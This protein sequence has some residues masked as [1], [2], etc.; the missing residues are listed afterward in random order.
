MTDLV[1]ARSTGMTR[2]SMECRR[3]FLGTSIAMLLIVLVGFAPTFYLRSYFPTARPPAPPY[4]Y[5]HGV[6]MTAWYLLLVAQTALVSARRSD[7]HR[8]LGIAG[9]VVAMGVLGTGLYVNTNLV[10]RLAALGVQL[11]PAT[12]QFIAFVVISGR[13]FLA[14]FAMLVAAAVLLRRHKAVH[15]RLM[16]LASLTTIGAALGP[17][18]WLGAAAVPL[19]PA[20]VG[21]GSVVVAAFIAAL[22]IRDW[23]VERRLHPVTLWGGLALI[24]ALPFMVRLVARAA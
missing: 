2:E 22:C 18:R 17:D 14:A 19:L 4:A 6:V 20:G 8:R 13:F 7:L 10:P 11:P 1:E 12:E 23:F 3:F 24:V 16:F 9:I 15:A 5:W 21:L